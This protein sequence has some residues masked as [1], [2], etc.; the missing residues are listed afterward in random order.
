MRKDFGKISL[1]CTVQFPRSRSF[2]WLRY[3]LA[4]SNAA[5]HNLQVFLQNARR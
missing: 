2:F 1:T 3:S 4:T 5:D